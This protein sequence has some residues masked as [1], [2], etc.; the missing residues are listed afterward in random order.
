MKL[1]KAKI[2]KIQLRLSL[3]LVILLFTNVILVENAFAVTYSLQNAK[4]RFG[5]GSEDSLNS[6]GT[7]QQPFYKSSGTFY[8]LTFSTYP[9]DI[10]IGVG[11]TPNGGW[12]TS[13]TIVATNGNSAYTV[14]SHTA[15]YSG[16]IATPDVAAN[17]GYGV[18]TSTDNLTVSSQNI[19]V[20]TKYS[21]GIND[22]FIKI[23]TSIKNLSL[24]SLTNLRTWVGTRDDWVGS[25]DRPT[26]TRGNITNGAFTAISSASTQSHAIQINSGSEGVL[27]YS[28]SAKAQTSV[29]NCCNFGSATAQDPSTAAITLTNDGSYALF[30]AMNDVASQ[31]TSETLTWY[32]AAGAT[33]DLASIVTTVSAANL[34]LS[35][36]TI[37]AGT[38]SPTF[39][40]SITSY[41]DTVTADISTL[42][43]TPTATDSGVAT[44]KV[45][46]NSGTYA[47]VSSGAASSSLSMN[48]GINTVYVQVT[49]GDSS[50][51]V[52]TISV[53]RPETPVIT[54]TPTYLST[55]KTY[56][57]T[58]TVSISTS[59]YSPTGTFKFT[60]NGTNISGCTTVSIS[61]GLALCSW[62]PSSTGSK[63]L[64]ATYSGDTYVGLNSETKTVTV[65]D[66][67][68]ITSD[69]S[70]IT[71][72][73][74]GSQTN[75][76]ITYTGGS[77]TK[78]VTASANSLASGK[79]IFT[80]NLAKLS[81]DTHTA[82]GT[83]YETITVTDS[84][85]T[86]ASYVQTIL[87]TPADTLTIIADTQTAQTYSGSSANVTP[88]ISAL[89]GLVSGDTLNSATFNFSASSA[90][91][92]NGGLCNVG[93]IGPSGGYVF[94]VSPS[95]INVA[96]GISAGGIYLEAAPVAAQST[97]QFGCTGTQ[98]P[99]TSYGVGSGA[100]NTL[101][102]INSCATAGIAARVTSNLT[103]AGFS[104][105][106]MP[107]LDE[108]T[109]IYN[110]LFNKSPS[111]GGFTGVD[112]GS[113]SE[114]TNGY[115]YQAYW[116][117]GAG[118]TSGQT[119]KNYV[120][121]YRPIRA[122]NPTYTSSINYGPS[123]TKPTDAGTYTLTPSAITFTNGASSNYVS[124]SY[125]SSLFAINK[126]QQANLYLTSSFG[127]FTTSPSTLKLAS[128]GGS[129]TGT[130]TYSVTSGGSATGCA[131]SGDLLTAFSAGTCLVLVTK[132]ETNNFLIKYSETS[133]V[134][135]AIFIGHQPIQTQ[136]VP[137][138]LPIN[139][140]NALDLSQT[141]TVPAITGVFLV[142]STY[143][144]NGTGF[145]DVTRVVIGGTEA[146]ISSSTATKIVISSAGLM[147][148]P[149]FIE[150]SDGRIGPS[151]F[152]FFA[153]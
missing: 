13:G 149:L 141:N 28:S 56:I 107:S 53:F 41:A 24:T 99:G 36:L 50:T 129:D 47:S 117:F 89:S 153:P 72:K 55:T 43:V 140:Q 60:E 51:A 11:G 23:E 65:N 100:A 42:T 124:I 31:A 22:A 92:S 150:C 68:A 58:L 61:V 146:T 121:Y 130:I 126:A 123:T 148:G 109:A 30:M 132:A 128:I 15:D 90:S 32:Y 73:Y 34:T 79:I 74:G 17:S 48:V 139:G 115:G 105:W 4:L 27:F 104:D 49:G 87:I 18:I 144:I 81:I 135:F 7:M 133:T 59:V 118:A 40:S 67:I 110:N 147:P 127:V 134:T 64:V 71:Q 112:Y 83:Y 29:N 84:I 33:A 94:Y 151:P 63:T 91:C 85:N 138:Q 116:W 76:V 25:S 14:T 108:M 125:V 78:V 142:G 122:F 95:V 35:N 97:A 103:Y 46:A 66:L 54:L 37:S 80:S 5:T 98:T 131:L 93:D 44:I 8:K 152:Y 70:T 106:F 2:N 12:N 77:D 143:E 62:A 19:Q 10:A 88:T 52:T 57:D 20:I 136:S 119:N 38:L 113:S 137:T 145:T 102:I 9:L 1:R 45:K 69:T 114:G 96:S 111:L 86:Y 39:S 120:A 75:R 26:K 82:V 16:F 101:A 3:T 6:L 21:L